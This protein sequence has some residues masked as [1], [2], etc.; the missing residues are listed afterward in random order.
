[1]SCKKNKCPNSWANTIN[2]R[3][4]TANDRISIKCSEK[5]DISDTS[6][7]GR[8]MS[9]HVPDNKSVKLVI[10][11]DH[12]HHHHSR[13]IDEENI[14][15]CCTDEDTGGLDD[16]ADSEIRE[17]HKSVLEL[18]DKINGKARSISSSRFHLLRDQIRRP[19][20]CA[21][22]IESLKQVRN[23]LEVKNR[24]FKQRLNELQQK[25]FKNVHSWWDRFG[26]NT[27]V[28]TIKLLDELN[29]QRK[30]EL[31]DTI[32]LQRS[33]EDEAIQLER[34]EKE[35]QTAEVECEAIKS[36][37]LDLLADGFRKQLNADSE[38]II[39]GYTSTSSDSALQMFGPSTTTTMSSIHDVSN[40]RNDELEKQI[41]EEIDAWIRLGLEQGDGDDILS[42]D[43]DADRNN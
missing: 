36:E 9:V 14:H 11:D 3:R 37:I 15:S 39:I 43:D 42:C 38:R 16:D 21:R 25:P 12:H 32:G 19:S 26:G 24:S 28:Q 34:R 41:D 20:D 10:N 22:I 27:I 30:S 6:C 18:E 5:T 2:F 31:D 8:I 4:S 29:E 1:M 17:L 7:G 40:D 13:L 35:L 33:I 23:D